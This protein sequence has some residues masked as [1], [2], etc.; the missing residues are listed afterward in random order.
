MYRKI[1]LLFLMLVLVW[2]YV[3][4]AGYISAMTT[5]ITVISIV[6]ILSILVLS[7]IY[8]IQYIQGA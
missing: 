6:I 4:S 2:I 1:Y 3:A 7:P 5:M 8:L